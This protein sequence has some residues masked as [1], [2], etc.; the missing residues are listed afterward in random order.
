MWNPWE[1]PQKNILIVKTKELAK[2]VVETKDLA[3]WVEKT[4]DLAIC[5]R[6]KGGR[7]MSG[8]RSGAARDLHTESS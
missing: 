4:K 5:G 7:Q 6:L 1:W 8:Q 3:I 2:L